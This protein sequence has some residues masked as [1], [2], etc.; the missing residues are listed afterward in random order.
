MLDQLGDEV[1]A[2]GSHL[3][4]VYGKGSI[5]QSGLHRRIIEQLKNSKIACTEYG[6]VP[7][8]PRLSDC[9]KGIETARRAAVDAILAVGGGS[10]IDTA[11]AIAAGVGVEHDVWK[12]FSGKKTVRSALPLL[13]VPTVA[14]SGSEINHAMVLTHDKLG[15]KFGFAHRHLYPRTCIADPDLTTTVSPE[16][17]AGGG[18]DILCHCLEPYMTTRA[19]NVDLQCGLLDQICATVVNAIPAAMEQPDAYS[20]RA[21]LLWSAMLAMSPATTAGLGRVYHTL[22]LLE[23]GLSAHH[24][25]AHGTGLAA[26]LPGWFRYHQEEWH[27][28]IGRWGGSVFS[29]PRSSGVDQAEAALNELTRFLYAVG[30]P[31]SL[32]QLGVDQ[33]DLGLLAEHAAAANRVRPIPGFDLNKA[34][35]MLDC[36]W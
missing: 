23:H 31:T 16:Q 15:H 3:L 8:N 24:D 10:V 4:F 29:L 14:G 5:K 1:S 28:R 2:L 17:T 12:F 27:E 9:R 25:I 18:V 26:L 33:M 20:P 7:A 13:T 35:E 19:G 30:C 36:C 6:N 32:S 22:H 34:R 11:K 21:A